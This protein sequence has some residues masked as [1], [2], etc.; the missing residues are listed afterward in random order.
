MTIYSTRK[1]PEKFWLLSKECCRQ[2]R[3]KCTIRKLQY[4]PQF[5]SS[6]INP[7]HI[8]M[9]KTLIGL[10]VE[11]IRI[12]ILSASLFKIRAVRFTLNR[13]NWAPFARMNFMLTKM[14][15]LLVKNKKRWSEMLIIN[16]TS[17]KQLRSNIREKEINLTLM[18]KTTHNINEILNERK[19]TKLSKSSCISWT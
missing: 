7:D 16:I 6:K 2:L 11:V 1:L 10:A 18:R 12:A 3:C 9:I 5:T 17:I 4:L 13:T 8:C 19:I 14:R 15:R